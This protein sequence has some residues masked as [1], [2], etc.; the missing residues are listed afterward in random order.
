[1]K[2]RKVVQSAI[3]PRFIDKMSISQI[4]R[5]SESLDWSNVINIATFLGTVPNSISGINIIYLRE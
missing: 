2:M 4:F 3:G 1:M 5:C